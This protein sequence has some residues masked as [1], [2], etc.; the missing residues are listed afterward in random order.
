M[1]KLALLLV[2]L[3][4]I[5]SAGFAVYAFTTQ[6][7]QAENVQFPIKVND[8]KIDTAIPM[9]CIDGRVYLQLRELGSILG[10]GIGWSEEERTVEI[11]TDRVEFGYDGIEEWNQID[12]NITKETALSIGDAV[13]LQMFGKEY[14][15]STLINARETEDKKGFYVYRYVELQP[16]GGHCI[17]VRKSDGKILRISAEE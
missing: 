3:V 2:S 1:K 4:L 13:F 12:L 10:I 9:V 11:V 6:S 15:E 8:N 17:T 14:V 5:A 7:I 16:G